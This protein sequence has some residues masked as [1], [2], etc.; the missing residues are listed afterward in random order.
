MQLTIINEFG[1]VIPIALSRLVCA[2][3]AIAPQHSVSSQSLEIP[4]LQRV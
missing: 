1:V 3:I 4:S 2:V